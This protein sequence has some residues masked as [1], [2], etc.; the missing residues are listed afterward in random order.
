[1]M[2]K[3]RGVG[4]VLEGAHAFGH[5]CVKVEPI[6]MPRQQTVLLSKKRNR[7][8]LHAREPTWRVAPTK[9]KEDAPRYAQWSPGC[10]LV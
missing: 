4:K 2:S 8:S 9:T 5:E 6:F 7:Y 1:M 10:F 3:F